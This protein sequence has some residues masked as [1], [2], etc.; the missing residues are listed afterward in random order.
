[1]G[2]QIVAIIP[3]RYESTRFPGKPLA[4]IS[5]K[6]MIE[7]V[8]QQ[9]AKCKKFADII[10]ATDDERI[11]R[12]VDKFG[13][14]FQMT[15]RGIQ[16]GTERAWDVFRNSQYDAVINIQGDEPL[17]SDQLISKTYDA[18]VE[19][20]DRVVSAFY[21]N[22][23][24][25]DFYSRHIV[26]VTLDN[27][28]QALYFSRAPIPFQTTEQFSFFYQHIGIYGYW[29]ETLKKIMSLPPSKLE[30]VEKLEQL[31]FLS[32]GIMIKLIESDYPSF[33]VDVPEDVK[34][35]ERILEA[36]DETN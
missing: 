16:S 30:L 6:P 12:T 13:G 9:V 18:V 36:E 5:G 32:N 2:F 11:A 31:R 1:M 28:F 24:V 21:K 3:A 8:Y 33:G 17:L 25:E 15:S 26:K 4:K 20:K 23:S 7:L 29:R 14:R 22:S 34:K 35:I 19:E 27:T 10:V